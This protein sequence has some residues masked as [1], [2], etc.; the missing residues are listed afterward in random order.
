MRIFKKI[1]SI[2]LRVGISVI[3]LVIVLRFNKIDTHS[4]MQ[5]IRRADKFMLALA[6][7][8]FLFNYILSLLRWEMLLKAFKVHL[9]L[10][11]VIT[12]FAGGTFF[13]LFLPSTIGGDFLRSIDL[14]AH[15]KKPKEIIA[16]VFLDRLSGYIGLVIL[17]LFSMIIGWPLIHDKKNILFA[18]A[19]I[20]AILSTLLFILFN[21]FIYSKISRLLSSSGSG[22][23]RELLKDL[24]EEIHHFKHHKKVIVNSLILSL[25]I[26]A[27]GPVAFFVIALSLGIKVSPV[28]FF[29]F[30]PV[31]GAITLLP[32]SIGGL[33]LRE[34]TTVIF[35]SQVGISQNL[36]VAMSLLN[37]SFIFVCGALGGLIYVFT[38]HHRRIQ[39]HKS[40]PIHTARL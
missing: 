38:V 29:I 4:L 27:T 30:L 10:K 5:D 28:Y 15:T 37:T 16:T 40:F 23:I 9:P 14:A 35:F 25:F 18:I 8:I 6:F 3:L 20:T 7:G 32:V 21:K 24:H 33:G 34:M 26:Q 19:V 12:S 17:V 2:F 11:R 36:T 39:H 22:K 31:I 13:N 1:L